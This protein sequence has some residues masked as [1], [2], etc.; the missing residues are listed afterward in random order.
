VARENEAC[1]Q[2][3]IIGMELDL[4]ALDCHHGGGET[5]YGS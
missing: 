5:E 3:G 4:D 1:A 2:L